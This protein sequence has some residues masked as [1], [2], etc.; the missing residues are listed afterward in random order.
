[1]VEPWH[2]LA[3]ANSFFNHTHDVI[4]VVPVLSGGP[5]IYTSSMDVAKQILGAEGK[6]QSFKPPVIA[7]GLLLWGNN[8]ATANGETWKRHRR[9][10]APALTSQTY[11]LVVAETIATYRE[12]I[13]AEDWSVDKDTLVADFNRLP[14][15]LAL[16]LIARCGFGIPMPWG[17]PPT[18]TNYNTFANS[19]IIVTETVIPR[20]L[21]PSWLY[22][23]PINSIRTIGEAWSS[24]VSFMHA[25]IASRQV[26]LQDDDEQQG[27][28]LS[29]LVAAMGSDGK[30][31]LD[32]QEVL[33]NI[34]TLTFTGHETTA[35]TITATL[36]YLAIYE[37][38]QE[39]AYEEIIKAVPLSADPTLDDFQN[40]PQ[41]LACFHEAARIYPAGF[42][43][44]RELTDDITVTVA[45][46]TQKQMALQKGTLV[47]I[48]MIAIRALKPCQIGWM[49]YFFPD[50]NPNVYSEPDVFRPSRWYGVP[51]HEISMFGAGPRACIGKKF[52]HLE[53]LCFLFLFLRDWR[54]SVPLRD[55]ETRREYEERVMGKAGMVGSGFGVDPLS[56]KVTKR[57]R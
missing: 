16:I 2:E 10:V 4:S 18:S 9:I 24:F 50:H 29:R 31:S 12:T 11:N 1:M 36:G 51:D 52:A 46:P 38:E 23:L 28:I 56:L 13:D 45:R 57:S 44:V 41:L 17:D 15:K 47:A 21:V 33:G 19:L 40:L 20:L 3:S 25:F 48:D 26:E 55:R 6:T 37:E 14:R 49:N 53:A 8:L 39:K 42:T 27:D 54:V 43:I 32:E 34:F 22:K 5:S 30:L 7:V 35:S